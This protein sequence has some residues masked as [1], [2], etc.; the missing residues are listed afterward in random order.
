MKSQDKRNQ[1]FFFFFLLNPKY[2]SGIL[3]AATSVR[4]VKMTKEQFAEQIVVIKT[5]GRNIAKE[6]L[7]LIEV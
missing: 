6:F 3:K 2:H 5:T 4:W 7:Q 1:S